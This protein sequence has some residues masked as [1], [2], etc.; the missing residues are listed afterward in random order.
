MSFIFVSSLI[1]L[2]L[3]CL[4]QVVI[5]FVSGY[6]LFF[7][8]CREVLS[9]STKVPGYSDYKSSLTFVYL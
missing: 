3:K 8:Q 5:T 1:S 6:Y 4:Y 9:S 2:D 7:N